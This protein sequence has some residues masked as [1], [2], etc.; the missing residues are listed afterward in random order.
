MNDGVAKNRQ[1]PRCAAFFVTAVH[2]EYAAAKDLRALHLAIFA[3]P[4]PR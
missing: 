4:F 3:E 2:L 1:L